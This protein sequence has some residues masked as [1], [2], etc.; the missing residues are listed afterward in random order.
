MAANLRINTL[1][2][3]PVYL[4]KYADSYTKDGGNLLLQIVGIFLPN[5]MVS[6]QRSEVLAFA[7]VYTRFIDI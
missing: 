2:C 3:D 7:T 1:S 5:C 6:P 4:G